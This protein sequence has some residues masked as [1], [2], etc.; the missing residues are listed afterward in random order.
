M[1]PGNRQPR[2]CR[3]SRIVTLRLTSGF[4]KVLESMHPRRP[5]AWEEPDNYPVRHN[6]NSG[7]LLRQEDSQ[8]NLPAWLRFPPGRCQYYL[9]SRVSDLFSCAWR[10]LSTAASSE[11]RSRGFLA[12]VPSVFSLSLSIITPSR[13]VSS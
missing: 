4:K 9:A 6:L 7:V 1:R 12:R 11:R 5:W 2:F 8:S 3:A 10:E 13:Y